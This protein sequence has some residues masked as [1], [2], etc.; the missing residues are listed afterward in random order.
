MNVIMN[1]VFYIRGTCSVHGH[2]YKKYP[3]T[4]M[5]CAMISKGVKE[6]VSFWDSVP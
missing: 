5:G 6:E 1:M 4:V 3:L 2:D